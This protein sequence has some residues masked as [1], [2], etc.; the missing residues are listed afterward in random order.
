MTCVQLGLACM[1]EIEAAGGRLDVVFTLRDDIA[2]DKSGRVHVDGFCERHGADLVKVRNINDE[3]AVEALREAALDRLFIIGWSQ[4]AGRPVLEA[5]SKGVL[6]MHPTLLPEGRGRAAIPWTIIKGLPE[7]GVTLFKLDDGVDTGP[8]LAQEKL[9]VA[10]D[11]TAGTLY[12]RVVE[13]HRRLIRRVWAGL[14]ADS[15]RP[16]PQDETRATEWPARSPEDGRI[17][18]AMT[19]AEADRL[20]RAVTHPYPGAFWDGSDGRRLL[21]WAGSREG[22]DGV[23]IPLVDGTYRATEYEWRSAPTEA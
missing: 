12:E 13:A 16:E 1:E 11:E 18:S 4:I 8:I 10:P 9:A 2:R 17:T 22:A 21:V 14:L 5:P 3:D 7:T 19:V 23:G 6:G 15:I 20:V